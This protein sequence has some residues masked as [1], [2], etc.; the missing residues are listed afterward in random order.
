MTASFVSP[1]Q[2]LREALARGCTLEAAAAQ[3]QVSKAFAAVV[4]EDMQR[5][6][7][8]A[9]AQSLCASGLGAC[10]GNHDP[11]VA[12]HCAGCPLVI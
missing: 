11:Q 6:G 1:V 3:A 5:R 9:S 10:H 2:R 7:Q 4:I 8:A 12:L